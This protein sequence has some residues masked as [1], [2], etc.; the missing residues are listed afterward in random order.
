MINAKR[1]ASSRARRAAVTNASISSSASNFRRRDQQSNKGCGGVVQPVECL[2]GR[3]TFFLITHLFCG[4]KVEVHHR[5]IGKKRREQRDAREPPRY[6]G[7]QRCGIR[8]W[9]P[10]PP[11][12]S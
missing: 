5:N 12:T 8:I 1:I 6:L 4:V 7:F 10:S 11:V 2:T 3:P 9:P